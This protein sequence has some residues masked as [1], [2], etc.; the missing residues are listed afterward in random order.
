MLSR[1]FLSFKFWG[2]GRCWR[3]FSSEFRRS[4]GEMGD[5]ST[6]DLGMSPSIL[7][8]DDERESFPVYMIEERTQAQQVISKANHSNRSHAVYRGGN[9]DQGPAPC[10]SW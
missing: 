4:M 8:S 3:C 2:S 1:I 6:E 9:A 5:S 10:L 7:E